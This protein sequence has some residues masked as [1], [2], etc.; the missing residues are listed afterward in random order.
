MQ[1]RNFMKCSVGTIGLTLMAHHAKGQEESTGSTMNQSLTDQM[2]KPARIMVED[3]P[4][5]SFISSV[6]HVGEPISFGTQFH[7]DLWP[8]SW[9]KDG[10]TY[11]GIGDG[12]GFSQDKF[13]YTLCQVFEVD[14]E[15]GIFSGKDVAS[16]Y[17]REFGHLIINEFGEQGSGQP[18]VKP[19]GMLALDDSLYFIIWDSS[20]SWD[21]GAAKDARLLYSP[22]LGKTWQDKGVFFPHK[23]ITPT[24]LQAGKNYEDA[25][26]EYAYLYSPKYNWFEEDELF[27]ARV[28]KEKIADRDSYEFFDGTPE[29]PSWTKDIEWMRPTFYC[30]PKYIQQCEVIYTKALERYIMV[31]WKLGTEKYNPH[32]FHYSELYMVESPTPWGPWSLFHYDTRWGMN[33]QDYRY[34]GRIP[35]CLISEDGLEFYLQ[36]SGWSPAQNSEGTPYNFTVQKMKLN[37]A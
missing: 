23:F 27:L 15:K 4:K 35:A 6:E 9:A 18:N 11:A 7:G 5:S 10:K 16:E 17:F 36:Y 26:D 13:Y 3:I 34:N 32:N 1:R 24:F 25:Q 19:S 33:S 22:D 28:P 21:Y 14:P 8:M 30:P 20:P 2:A 29:K 37:L 31:Q 12:Y